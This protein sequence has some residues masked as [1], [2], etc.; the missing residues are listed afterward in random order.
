MG[1][2]DLALRPTDECR[3]GYKLPT[4]GK[5]I[6]SIAMYLEIQDT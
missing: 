4:F 5:I 1:M 6:G 2:E 3:V